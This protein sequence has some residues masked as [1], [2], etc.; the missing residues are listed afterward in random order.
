MPRI[1]PEGLQQLQEELHRLKTAGRR[2]VAD[3]LRAARQLGD[4]VNN[5][6]YQQALAEHDRLERRIAELE[7]F[8]QAAEVVT[9]APE[10]TVGLGS[11]VEVRDLTTGEHLRFRVVGASE[12]GPVEELVSA[13]S[14]VGRALLGRRPGE[15]AEARLPGG[16]IVR[17]EVLAIESSR[18]SA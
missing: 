8:L 14:P 17:F 12:T 13:D 11:R 2:Q 5:E 6:D 9:A 7:A 10:G 15:V 4:L 18:S 1:T 16:E 3:A